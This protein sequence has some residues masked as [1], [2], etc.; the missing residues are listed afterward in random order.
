MQDQNRVEAE[1]ILKL[2]GGN[3]L[4]S[5]QVLERQLNV[6]HVRAQ[7]LMTFSGVVV[8]VTGF[9]GKTIAGTSL[10]AKI[11]I[12]AGLLVV[13]LGAIWTWNKVMGIKWIT[14]DIEGQPLDVLTRIIKRRSAKTKAYKVGGI[15]LCVGLLIYGLAVGQMLLA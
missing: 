13:L 12:V 5:L 11:S 2:T 8:T 14:S 6:L 10:M 7:I 4:E 15:M 1:Q 9:S 3:L